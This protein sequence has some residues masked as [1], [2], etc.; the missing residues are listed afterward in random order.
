MLTLTVLAL[1]LIVAFA[2]MV[3]E[4]GGGGNPAGNG[5]TGD[6]Y[7]GDGWIEISSEE[8]LSLVGSGQTVG[9]KS[10]PADGKYF[11]TK[12]LDFNGKDLNGGFD[13]EINISISS[14]NLTVSLTYD[15][16]HLTSSQDMLISVDGV[17]KKISP[18]RNS[19]RF[20]VSPGATSFNITVGGM[21]DVNSPFAT[22]VTMTLAEPQATRNSNG[23]MDSLCIADPFMGE[24]DGNGKT[25]KGLETATFA[26]SGTIYAGLFAQTG[27][28]K[29]IDVRLENG[30]SVAVNASSSLIHTPAA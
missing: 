3:T 28:A 10:Y 23:N 22:A 11:L 4:F 20:T 12:N 15:G 29:L 2:P 18:G 14:N 16:G 9:G 19:E 6:I 25:I 24:F 7:S 8:E 27:D 5:V 1:F 26:S 13:F 30:S 17:S 21:R